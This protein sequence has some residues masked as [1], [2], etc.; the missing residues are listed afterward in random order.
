MLKLGDTDIPKIYLG[1]EE[2][3]KAYLG[4]VE[5][6]SGDSYYRQLSRANVDTLNVNAYNITLDTAVTPFYIE[7]DVDMHRMLAGDVAYLFSWGGVLRAANVGGTLRVFREDTSFFQIPNFLN[8]YGSNGIVKLLFNYDSNGMTLSVDGIEVSNDPLNIYD[9]SGSAQFWVNSSGRSFVADLDLY[10]LDINGEVWDLNED[11]G[12]NS[13]SNLGMVLLGET[14]EPTGLTYWNSTVIKATDYVYVPPVLP[15][16]GNIYF[17]IGQSNMVGWEDVSNATP[18]YTGVIPNSKVWVVNQWKDVEA[19]VAGAPTGQ[20]GMIFA[21]AYSL[22][23]NDPNTPNYFVHVAFAST[24]VATN[25][26]VGLNR[27]N[28]AIGAWDTA[29]ATGNY[30]KKAI[31]WQQG[32]ADAKNITYANDYEVDEGLM[33]DAMKA[34]T[35]INTFVDGKLGN[36]ILGTYPYISEVNTAKDN[37]LINNKSDF[38]IDTSDL[39]FFDNLHFDALSY[40]TLGLRYFDIV[41]NL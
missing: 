37:N 41:K 27:Y 29:L 31:L 10:G 21:L 33:I 35:G 1:S 6:Y 3:K 28:D 34:H 14:D 39:T 16:D 19:G 18:T 24:S 8:D 13:S 32:E 38:T 23:Q 22:N 4:S 15:V 11:E 36:V 17:L 25:W 20:Y 9:F 40:E 12:F 5:V 7:M 2:V 30:V 26:G